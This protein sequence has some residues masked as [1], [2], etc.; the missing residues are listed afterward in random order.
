[1]Y[2][3]EGNG[4]VPGTPNHTT[5]G[6]PPAAWGRIHGTGGAYGVIT[7]QNGSVLQYE[8]VWNNG[9]GGEGEVTDTWA[10]T[11]A[12]HAQP[13]LPPPLPPPP[14]APAPKPLPPAGLAWEC[15]PGSM[16]FDVPTPNPLK[17]KDA[18]RPACETVEA[19]EQACNAAATCVAL[20]FHGEDKHCHTLSGLAAPPLGHG[21]WVAG[22]SNASD[23]TY[24]SCL[25][26]R[27]SKA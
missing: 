22:L 12:T 13:P 3:T 8:H 15:A 6:K 11:G 25:L 5:L 26:V 10:I 1:M 14:P 17:L 27:A 9:A 7:A 23:A 18:L 19:C 4:A 20:R 21:A 16:A 24:T 2:I